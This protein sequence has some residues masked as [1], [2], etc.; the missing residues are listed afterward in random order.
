MPTEPRLKRLKVLEAMSARRASAPCRTPSGQETDPA[1][2][3]A[4]LLMLL[5]ADERHA[6]AGGAPDPRA[7]RI[8][9][10][11]GLPDPWAERT[12]ET[13]RGNDHDEQ[14]G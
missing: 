14:A 8:R 6:Q 3:R 13:E 2:V 9:A 1:Q 4:I 7:C 5:E 10:D 12:T 11:L